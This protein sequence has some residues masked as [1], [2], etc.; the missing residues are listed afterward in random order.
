LT[1]LIISTRPQSAQLDCADS[2][3][4]EAGAR[5]FLRAIFGSPGFDMKLGMTPVITPT[6]TRL[7]M[8]TEMAAITNMAL[9]GVSDIV[10]S[11]PA[12]ACRNSRYLFG[13]RNISAW[14]GA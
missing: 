7:K 4:E 6:P 13:I 11:A 1:K 2:A 8:I 12:V 3:L 10:P 14:H 5:G 9:L